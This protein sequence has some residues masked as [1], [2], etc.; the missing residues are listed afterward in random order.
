MTHDIFLQVLI[1]KKNEK[2]NKQ[3]IK[4]I[5]FFVQSKKKLF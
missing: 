4:K 5:L 1:S 2:K 3:F